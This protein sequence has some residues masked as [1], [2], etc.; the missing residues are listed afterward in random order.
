HSDGDRARGDNHDLATTAPLLG[1]LLA[2]ARENLA[3]DR[4]LLV[5]HDRRAEL[6]D[7]NSHLHEGY[8]PER[9][10]RWNG[11][12][13]SSSNT[14]PAISTSSP[15]SNPCASSARMTPSTRSRSST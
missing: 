12:P 4:A 14:I 3:P 2:D 8:A 13:G 15:G 10:Q 1:D 9:G 7:D 6:C 11:I 5:G